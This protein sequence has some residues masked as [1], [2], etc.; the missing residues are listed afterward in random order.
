MPVIETKNL[1]KWYGNVLG[2]S[3]IT[4]QIQGGIIGLLGPNGAGKSTFLKVISGQLKPNSGNV[5]VF[6][7]P[8]FSNYSL[9][10]RLSI[11]PE[12]DSFYPQISGFEQVEFFTKLHG[13]RGTEATDIAIKAIDQVGL[14]GKKDKKIQEYSLGMKQRIKIACAI[15][16]DPDLLLLDEPLRGIDPIWRSRIIQLIK[17][18]EIKGKTVIVSSHVLPEIEAM[19]N[20]IVLIHQGKVFAQGDIHE[21]RGLLN[22]YPHMIT[23]RSEAARH[24]GKVM[25][26]HPH[27]LDIQFSA[28]QTMVTFK[29]N[30][31]D[32]FYSDLTTA[33]AENRFLVTEILSS[34]DN[35]QAVFDYLIGK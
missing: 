16:C 4:L 26:D 14:L 34:D 19:T 13:F 12:S 1:S 8:V 27:V 18:L 31:R 5:K 32:R 24:L 7:E 20:S 22:R 29:T 15:A 17:E 33:I 3:E 23:V 6:E 35:L 21:I 28:D 2:I 30:A 11:C 9:F 10:K 25:I